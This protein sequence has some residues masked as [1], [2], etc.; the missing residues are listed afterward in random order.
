LHCFKIYSTIKVIKEGKQF[1]VLPFF[2][3]LETK[4]RHFVYTFDNKMPEK[5]QSLESFAF[6][7]QVD[8]EVLQE[9]FNRHNDIK[10]EFVERNE[11]TGNKSY[12]LQHIE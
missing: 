4:R 1:F 2:G 3:F 10:P 11:I 6:P 7:T 9:W 8:R 12:E 5:L